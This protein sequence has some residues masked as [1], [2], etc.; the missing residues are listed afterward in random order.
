MRTNKPLKVCPGLAAMPGRGE[1]CGVG[2]APGCAAPE[3]PHPG[4]ASPSRP[5]SCRSLHRWALPLPYV[6]QQLHDPRCFPR[7]EAA[8]QATKHFHLF[9]PARVYHCF[10]S[11]KEMTHNAQS[12]PQEVLPLTSAGILEH[13]PRLP[14]SS[15]IQASHSPFFFFI[16]AAAHGT[17][18]FI[19]L[20]L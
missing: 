6:I 16:A 7:I 3:H 18:I 2:S 9:P 4:R 15:H 17:D 12:A 1:P 5:C 8:F 14:V 13:L 10:A 11:Y 20:S 19:K